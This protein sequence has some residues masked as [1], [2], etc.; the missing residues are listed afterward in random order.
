MYH[1]NWNKLFAIDYVRHDQIS[2]LS[3]WTSFVHK[4]L[5][6]RQYIPCILILDTYQDI[7]MDGYQHTPHYE[8]DTTMQLNTD[9]CHL[10]KSLDNKKYICMMRGHINNRLYLFVFYLDADTGVDLAIG[11]HCNMFLICH[12]SYCFSIDTFAVP[13]QSMINS[14]IDVESIIQFSRY[15]LHAFRKKN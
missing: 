6:Q 1:I 13:P 2:Y 5:P 12:R 11:I 10:Y 9:K 3:N 15:F 8:I 14:M 7:F 4:K